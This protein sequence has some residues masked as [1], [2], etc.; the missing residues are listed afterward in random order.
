MP[1]VLYITFRE[2]GIDEQLSQLILHA[3]QRRE[4]IYVATRHMHKFIGLANNMD[5]IILEPGVS[6]HIITAGPWRSG[7]MILARPTDT[8]YT[9]E[10]VFFLVI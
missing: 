2:A 4:M 3:K 8:G 7:Y 6:I 5:T 10:I 9:L 1:Y